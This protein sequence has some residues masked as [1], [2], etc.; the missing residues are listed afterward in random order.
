M[1]YQ[2]K[3]Q[4][5]CKFKLCST[6]LVAGSSNQDKLLENIG[7]S[8]AKFVQCSVYYEWTLGS[9]CKSVH[10]INSMELLRYQNVYNFD[11]TVLTCQ[12][13]LSSFQGGIQ[14]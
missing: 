5:S 12:N 6:E 8:Q 7:D 14:N 2:N 10:F 11:L 9:V 13:G 3:Q 1:P 4:N